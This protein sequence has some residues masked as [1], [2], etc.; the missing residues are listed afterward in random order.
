MRR[1]WLLN[2]LI[3]AAAAAVF[4]L[5]EHGLDPARGGGWPW[6]LLAVMFAVADRCVVHMHFRESA[7]SFSLADIPLV[8]GLIFASPQDVLLGLV[9]GTLAVIAWERRL[10]P[11][12]IAFNVGQYLLAAAL[13][14]AIFHVIGGAHPGMDPRLWLAII[15]AVQ[16]SGTVTAL[17]IATVITITEG[18]LDIAG[19]LRMLAMDAAVGLTNPARGWG[20]AVVFD[21]EPLATPLL[22]LPAATVF[23]AYRAYLSERSP[24]D[25][26]EVVYET[27]RT[28]SRSPDVDTALQELLARSL[29]AF[30]VASAEVV[31]FPPD[32]RVPLRTVLT[33]DGAQETMQPIDA[34][35]GA[36]LGRVVG[37]ERPIVDLAQIELEPV[38][39]E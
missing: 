26:L 25:R 32:G 13:A 3:L 23:I 31:L 4:V 37:P 18:G 35:V 28:L 24:H 21:A 8:L 29:E 7:H 20:I 10:P 14:I 33:A 22:V 15:A 36:A 16:V 1:V 19:V 5:L 9:A 12:K 38:L 39:A 11:I 6:W 34:A 30:H 27:T 2:S 17:L